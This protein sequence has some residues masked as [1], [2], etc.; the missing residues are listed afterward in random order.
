MRAHS[1]TFVYIVRA[2]F[3]DG[4]SGGSIQLDFGPDG[5]LFTLI[6]TLT[7]SDPGSEP[8][9]DQAAESLAREFISRFAAVD[10][11]RLI[12]CEGSSNLVDGILNIYIQLSMF[13]PYPT[14]STNR[15]RYRFPET[16]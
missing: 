11:A 15:S 7:E 8:L 14:A 3:K 6:D 9:S 2:S 5:S 4:E 12:T 1:R 16:L 13:H 10:S